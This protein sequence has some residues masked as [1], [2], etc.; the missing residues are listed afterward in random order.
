VIFSELR[1]FLFFALVFAVYWA[2]R[3]NRSRKLWLIVAGLTFY[4]AWDWRF[5]SLIIYQTGVD[6]IAARKIEATNDSRIR[7]RWLQA[8]LIS[9]LGL[10]GIF[11]YLN[12]FADSFQTLAESAGFT[13]SHATLNIV[14]PVGISFYT[15][16]SLSYTIDVYRR[17]MTAVRSVL[18]FGMFVTFFPQ[19]VAGPIVRA[20]DFLP[21]LDVKRLAKNIDYRWALTLFLAGFFKKACV[22]D[23]ISPYVDA[24]YKA[25]ADYGT[26]SAWLAA[27]LY[28]VQI[29][30]DFSG[31]TDMAIACAALLGYRLCPNFNAPYLS[32]D[33]TDFWRR[34]HMS[35]SSWLRDYLYISLGGNR[36]GRIFTY[37]NLMLTMVLGGLWHGASWNFVLW[38]FMHGL[39]LIVHK[40]WK[41]TG[42]DLGAHP[43]ARPVAWLL[44]LGW[45]FAAWVPFRA[46]NFNDTLTTLKALV[47]IPA[48]GAGTLVGQGAAVLWLMIALLLLAHWLTHATRL[49]S[50]RWRLVGAHTYA[51]CY[52]I[53]WALVLTLKS[54]DY[55]PFIYFQF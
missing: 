1:F 50:E 54:T 22:S 3:T 36:G 44:T 49:V 5:L 2:L 25:P 41:K 8:S 38:G 18:D 27:S 34:W 14:L 30:C 15:F 26:L 19:L 32:L 12:F 31:Y 55:A 45:V 52:G 13:V 17:R 37:R 40:F 20:Y 47:G 4:A 23:N 10:L 16:Q 21:Q 51:F 29:Y 39:A 7:K 48:A 33:I 53:A 46:V 24:F 43:V 28:A 6:F 42:I 11:K 35:L 9:N